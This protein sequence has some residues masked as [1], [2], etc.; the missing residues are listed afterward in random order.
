V[1]TAPL[2][3]PCEGERLFAVLHEPAG[4]ARAGI[5][6]C[7]PILH[8]YVRSQ[9]LFALLAQALSEHGYRVLRFDYRGTGDSAGTDESFSLTWASVDAKAAVHSSVP[10]RIRNPRRAVTHPPSRSHRP[11]HPPPCSGGR[12]AWPSLCSS[13]ARARAY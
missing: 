12:R 2:W 5:V 13:C 3:I 4:S 7:A 9:R 1:K 6:F 11:L 10:P 8:E